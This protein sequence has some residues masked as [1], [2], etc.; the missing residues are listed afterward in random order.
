MGRQHR[1]IGILPVG[2][3]A[4]GGPVVKP[5]KHAKGREKMGEKVSMRRQQSSIGILPVGW[6]QRS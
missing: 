4:A 6:G 3:G 1:S 2:V 5:A